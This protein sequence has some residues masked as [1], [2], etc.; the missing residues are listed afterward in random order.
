MQTLLESKDRLELAEDPCTSKKARGFKYLEKLRRAGL[1]IQDSKTGV[2]IPFPI[3]I[4]VVISTVQARIPASLLESLRLRGG[5]WINI[6]DFET[7][8]LI[9][10]ALD[11][12]VSQDGGE[13][14]HACLT[15]AAHAWKI[16]H[17]NTVTRQT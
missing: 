13:W 12:L 7:H 14:T 10:K 9:S 8:R 11:D 3:N 17:R 6:C 1:C 2:E 15:Y 16:G 5:E 4:A